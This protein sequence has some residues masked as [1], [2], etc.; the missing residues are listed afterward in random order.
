MDPDSNYMATAIDEA[1]K[2]IGFTSP[3]PLVGAVIVKDGKMIGRGYHE[4]FGEPHAERNALADCREDPAEADMYVTLEPCCHYGH[5]PPCTEAII[6]AGIRRVFVGSDDPNPLVAGK[7][8]SILRAAGITVKTGIMKEQCDELNEIFFHYITAKT[9]YVILKAAVSADGKTALKNG[10]SK[11]ITS[12][13]SRSHAHNWRKRAAAILVGVN[14]VITDD[15]LLNCRTDDPSD[16]V[17]VICDSKLRT[18]IESQIVKTSSEIPVY[19]AT[20]CRDEKR[21]KVYEDAGVH[22]I[23]SVDDGN[24]RIDLR[25]LMRTLGS[26]Q[27]DSVLIEGGASIHASA[28]KSGIVNK[29]VFYTAPK[30]IGAD[31]HSAI[32]ALDIQTMDR[33]PVMK[34]KKTE[35][36]DND[37]M[38]EYEVGNVYGNN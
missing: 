26:M 10:G 5:Q 24:G 20:L 27:L 8:I 16:P 19:I 1:Q 36:L 17:R 7:G 32:G 38:A 35:I 37:I 30:M 18:P 28:I 4:K 25:Q 14:T 21:I 23:A 13:K 31:G 22:I 15:P 11:W 9:P 3:N 33:V 6:A 29:A 34:L 2:G 12:E